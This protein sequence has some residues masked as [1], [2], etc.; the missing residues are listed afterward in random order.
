[1]DRSTAHMVCHP[2]NLFYLSHVFS[3]II[4]IIYTP[5]EPLSSKFIIIA[6]VLLSVPIKRKTHI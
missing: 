4:V 2:E 6:L 5:K 3:Q 1:M